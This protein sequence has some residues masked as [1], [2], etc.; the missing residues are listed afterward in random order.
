LGQNTG[1]EEDVASHGDVDSRAAEQKRDAARKQRE[2]GSE[3][4][5]LEVI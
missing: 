2:G 1:S 3:D 5:A 4:R